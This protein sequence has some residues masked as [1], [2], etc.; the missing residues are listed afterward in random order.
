MWSMVV[1]LVPDDKLDRF[2]LPENSTDDENKLA[3]HLR[4]KLPP[5]RDVFPIRSC[6][7]SK[8]VTLKCFILKC[9]SSKCVKSQQLTLIQ[10]Q[11][12]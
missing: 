11:G 10:N 2:G 7:I 3:F 9:V 5:S 6:V 1:A 4:P 12:L 8:S